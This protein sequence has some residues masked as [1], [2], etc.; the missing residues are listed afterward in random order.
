[1]ITKGAP[2]RWAAPSSLPT[3][4]ELL[5]ASQSVKGELLVLVVW[6]VSRGPRYFSAFGCWA[7]LAI[8]RPAS[9][10]TTK[11]LGMGL[12]ALLLCF[13]FWKIMAQQICFLDLEKKTHRNHQG[14]SPPIWWKKVGPHP[15]IKKIMKIC[16]YQHQR[17][18][19]DFRPSTCPGR[20][21][22]GPGR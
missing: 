20:K 19:P 17:S 15:V 13:F 1:M 14:T 3:F 7:N 9:W 5:P 16:H 22:H 6:S 10:K 11:I 4:A 2:F 21:M 8:S 18:R 12:F